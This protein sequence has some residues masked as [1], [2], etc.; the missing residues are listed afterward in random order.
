MKTSQ[1]IH[2]VLIVMLVFIV[3]GCNCIRNTES[4]SELESL[5]SK[6]LSPPPLSPTNK[7]EEP[8]PVPVP[9]PP[10]TIEPPE[11]AA[12]MAEKSEIK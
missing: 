3:M 6:S 11:T 7:L 10:A 2:S 4:V 5:S 9:A 8:L 12:I 1:F